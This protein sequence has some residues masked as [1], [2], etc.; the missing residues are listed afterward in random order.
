MRT[1]LDKNEYCNAIKKTML[2]ILEDEDLVQSDDKHSLIEYIIQFFKMFFDG[3]NENLVRDISNKI[4]KRAYYV[5]EDYDMEDFESSLHLSGRLKSKNLKT[6]DEFKALLK[7]FKYLESIPQPVQKSQEWFDQ[8]AGMFTASSAASVIG[9]NPYPNQGP[10]NMIVEKLGLGPPFPDNKFVHHGKKYE[11][12]ATMIYE[13][14]YNSRITEFGLLP[15]LSVPNVS[16]I[17]A[18][19]DG[20]A[21][22][23]TLNGKFNPMLGTM[24]EIKCPLSRKIN[25]SG[26]IDGEICPHYYWCQVQQQLECANLEKCDFWQC[27]LVEY[28]NRREWLLD[29]H[30]KT[31]NYREQ[32][33]LIPIAKNL[34]KGC[35]IQ[36]LPKVV[37]SEKINEIYNKIREENPDEEE[38]A[39]TKMADVAIEEYRHYR[40]VYIYPVDLNMSNEEYDEWTLQTITDLYSVF[41]KKE[42]IM[43]EKEKENINIEDYYYDKVLYW[44]LVKSHNVTIHRDRE[45]FARVKPKFEALWKRVLYYREHMDE[46]RELAAKL[47]KERDANVKKYLREKWKKKKGLASNKARTVSRAQKPRVM[48]KEREKDMFLSSSDEC[49]FLSDSYSD[50]HSE[51]AGKLYSAFGSDTKVE[52]GSDKVDYMGDSDKE[53]DDDENN[54]DDKL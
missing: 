1:V 10:D 16:F 7:H 3:I 37:E 24:L 4:L 48:S 8:R 28:A 35:V 20:I 25:I 13:N 14:I 11:P 29:V 47:D 34:M 53:F 23:Y 6:P 49:M 46:A 15:H 18:S 40:A 41:K 21:C 39:I 36:L 54:E 17:G 5:D 38:E 33:E 26:E 44:K 32:G 51:K 22:Q 42:K 19:P 2:D 52:D 9:D 27:E 31:K 12:T 30:H 43:L 50:D 45:W